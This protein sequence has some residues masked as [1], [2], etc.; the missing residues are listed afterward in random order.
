MELEDTLPCSQNLV[1][2]PI[3]NPLNTPYRK[4]VGK[5]SALLWGCWLEFFNCRMNG[6]VVPATAT[7]G[8]WTACM[9]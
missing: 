2:F 3:M 1:L 9:P 5:L 8:S 6:L 7:H 4:G